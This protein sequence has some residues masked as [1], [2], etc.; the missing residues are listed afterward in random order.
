[1]RSNNGAVDVF[2]YESATGVIGMAPILTI[3]IQNTPTYFGMDQMALHPN[4][5]K[6]YVSQPFAV[7]VYDATTGALLTTIEHPSLGRTPTGI[8]IAGGH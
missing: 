3:P 7:N 2:D 1:M 4:D 6:L 8:S 5:Q